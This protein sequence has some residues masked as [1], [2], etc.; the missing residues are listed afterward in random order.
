[1]VVLIEKLEPYDTSIIVFNN[2][3]RNDVIWYF[4][5]MDDNYK[6]NHN[7]RFYLTDNPQF[8]KY[9]VKTKI[10][11]CI[12][13]YAINKELFDDLVKN[14]KLLSNKGG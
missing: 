12:C 8:S 11:Q 9:R 2:K 14:G 4:N 13:A 3:V 10:T 7:I 5:S 1:M 6:N